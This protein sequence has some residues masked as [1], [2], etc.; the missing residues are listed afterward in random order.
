[1]KR[2]NF[3]KKYISR[4]MKNQSYQSVS[5]ALLRRV[6]A[7]ALEHI[8]QDLK[9]RFRGTGS[10]KGV[11]YHHDHSRGFLI[12]DIPNDLSKV[13]SIIRDDGSTPQKC[14]GSRTIEKTMDKV[15][16][17]TL[18][19]KPKIDCPLVMD[20]PIPELVLN[21]VGLGWLLAYSLQLESVFLVRNI[22]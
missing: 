18:P 16:P 4:K 19:K 21:F 17:N 8:P 11:H 15:V 3:I 2:G 9:W 1:M 14:S 5:T 22:S 20:I 6:R 10:K 12:D 13:I 7:R